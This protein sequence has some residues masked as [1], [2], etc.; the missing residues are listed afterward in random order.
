MELTLTMGII[1]KR[2]LSVRV[3]LKT[4]SF[5]FGG[6]LGNVLERVGIVENPNGFILSSICFFS[7]CFPLR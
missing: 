6:L 3:C 5:V 4:T 1:Q 7:V 2:Y